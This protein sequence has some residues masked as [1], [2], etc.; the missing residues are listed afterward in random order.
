VPA[1]LQHNDLGCWNILVEDS[2]FTVLDWESS[3]PSGLPLWDLVYFLTDALSGLTAPENNQE[4]QRRMLELLRGELG[5]SALLFKRVAAAAA[6]FGVPT[7]AVGPIVT[8][9]W[10]HHGLS[11]DARA[12]R[13]STQG[14]TTGAPSS[15]GPLQQIAGSWLSDPALGVAWAAFASASGS[16]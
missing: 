16:E 6:A 15:A 2:T 14:A 9:G 5:T 8:L 1:V 3:V 12:R 11:A 10:L 7:N 4:K 13:G